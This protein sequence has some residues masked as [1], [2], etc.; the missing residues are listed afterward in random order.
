MLPPQRQPELPRRPGR[1]AARTGAAPA[2]S[3]L[4]LRAALAL[5]GLVF[6]GVVAGLFAAAGW[7]V[8]AILLCI[9]GATAVVDLVVIGRRARQRRRGRPSGFGPT[10]SVGGRARSGSNLR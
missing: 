10:A 3:P 8:P 4:R 5:F 2:R 1:F 7:T 9:V 6:C